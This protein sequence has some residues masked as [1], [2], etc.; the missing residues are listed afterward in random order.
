MDN[1]RWLARVR[2]GRLERGTGAAGLIRFA[3]A[4]FKR[5]PYEC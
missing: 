2:G 1:Y 4:T 3:T 5:K